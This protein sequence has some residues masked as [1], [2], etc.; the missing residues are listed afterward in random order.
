MFSYLILISLLRILWAWTYIYLRPIMVYYHLNY[1]IL[2]SCFIAS[3]TIMK[4]KV[5]KEVLY[6]MVIWCVWTLWSLNIGFPKHCLRHTLCQKI[7]TF[8][9]SNWISVVSL[10]NKLPLNLQSVIPLAL[11]TCVLGFFFFTSTLICILALLFRNRGN[12]ESSA[13]KSR[14][15]GAVT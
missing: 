14:P 12:L 3:T 11:F 1:C 10:K 2:H 13:W 15:A 5:A 4:K 9:V 8:E 6:I 7:P